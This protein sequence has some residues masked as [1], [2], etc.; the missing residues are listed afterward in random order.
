MN[1][2]I[3]NDIHPYI[4]MYICTCVGVKYVVQS[5]AALSGDIA[6]KCRTLVIIET[7]FQ[8]HNTVINLVNTYLLYVS[9][10]HM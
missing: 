4:H 1:L 5:H 9:S 2:S 3:Y 7:S 8:L 10:M 6:F